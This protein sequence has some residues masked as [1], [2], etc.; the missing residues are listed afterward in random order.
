MNPNNLYSAPLDGA[1]WYKSSYTA[2]NDQ[3]VE[4][5]ELPALPAVAIR[6]SKNIELPAS[7]V[8]ATGW[9]AFVGALKSGTLVTA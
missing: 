5:A 6:D 9:T 4:I 8:S 7:R 2:S 1:T 3:C